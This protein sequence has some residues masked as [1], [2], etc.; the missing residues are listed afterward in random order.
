MENSTSTKQLLETYYK[1]FA[2][3]EGWESVISDDFKFIGG[4][5]TKT[6]PI[7]G[8]AAYIEVIKRFSRV[9][10]TMRVK[11]MIIEGENACVIGNYDYTFPNGVS[12][13]GD[14]AE[15]W[16]AKNGKLDALTIFFDTHTFDK[17]IPK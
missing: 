9:F 11:E 12:I 3:K 4:D 13:N 6:A 17:N 15:I 14:V 2:Q 7:V 10:Q 1:G 5:M 16:K 8:K